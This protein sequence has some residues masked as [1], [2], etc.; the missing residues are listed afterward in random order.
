MPDDSFEAPEGFCSARQAEKAVQELWKVNDAV[1]RHRRKACVAVSLKTVR[2]VEFISDYPEL[3]DPEFVRFATYQLA[4]YFAQQYEEG[5]AD[6]LSQVA[7]RWGALMAMKDGNIPKA[8]FPPATQAI[9]SCSLNTGDRAEG[10]PSSAD[11]FAW[12][13]AALLGMATH[14]DALSDD[15]VELALTWWKTCGKLGGGWSIADLASRFRRYDEEHNS[16]VAAQASVDLLDAMSSGELRG[17]PG[18][19]NN[20]AN[21]LRQLFKHTQDIGLLDRAWLASEDALSADLPDPARDLILANQIMIAISRAAN[22]NAGEWLREYTRKVSSHELSTDVDAAVSVNFNSQAAHLHRWD[23][24]LNGDVIALDRATAAAN[25]AMS[26]VEAAGLGEGP[27]LGTAC[28]AVGAA[29]SDR[30]KVTSDP[31]DGWLAAGAYRSEAAAYVANK[32]QQSHAFSN[33]AG[34][35]LQMYEAQHDFEGLEHAAQSIVAALDQEQATC[36][37]LAL[38]LESAAQIQLELFEAVGDRDHLDK[39]LAHAERALSMTAP[40]DPR[41]ARLEC[42]VAR[43]LRGLGL[44]DNQDAWLQEAMSRFDTAAKLAPDD[45]D[46]GVFRH[47]AGRTALELAMATQDAEAL[48]DARRRL[49][50]LARDSTVPATTRW[51]SAVNAGRL[52]LQLHDRK[53]ALEDQ[54]LGVDVLFTLAWRGRPVSAR[55]AELAPRTS[56]LSEA[57]HLAL[58]LGEGDRALQ[59]A[60]RGRAVVWQELLDLR[61]LEGRGAEPIE[62]GSPSL[63]SV[64]RRVRMLEARCATARAEHFPQSVIEQIEMDLRVADAEWQAI[65]GTYSQQAAQEP[66]TME[67]L[68][69]SLCEGQSLI[70][71][72]PGESSGFA[73]HLPSG[74]TIELPGLTT[75]GCAS[76]LSSYSE[77]FRRFLRIREQEAW[78]ELNKHCRRL[79]EWTWSTVSAPVFAVSDGV[80]DPASLHRIFWYALGPAALLPL[81]SASTFSASG[82]VA[83]SV[84]DRCTSASIVSLVPIEHDTTDRPLSPNQWR[85]LAA[86]DAAGLPTL[87]GARAEYRAVLHA[88]G[89]PDQGLDLHATANDLLEAIAESRAVHV[90]CHANPLSSSSESA[91]AMTDRGVGLSEIAFSEPLSLQWAFMSACST[92]DAPLGVADQG[93]S[94][95]SGLATLG[96]QHVIGTLWQ[97]SDTPATRFATMMYEELITAGGGRPSYTPVAVETATR[98]L[99]AEYE[100]Y[101]VVWAP[102]QY[103]TH[104]RRPKR[105]TIGI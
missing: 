3:S 91:V 65:R 13:E 64:A 32:H 90:A 73:L 68:S 45:W 56:T 92:A 72:C 60:E 82:E 57:V 26:I 49:R 99:R 71:L 48:A 54:S 102:Y 59:V 23:Y 11:V 83:D 95:A 37:E 79:L 55:F 30:Y 75:T 10:G 50:E 12:N 42:A 35:Q 89:I 7:F 31:R 21:A 16:R 84:L 22:G 18:F 39:A 14:A 66:V 29:Y 98:R 41:R 47:F 96:C 33:L 62:E 46:R 36:P 25:R 94:L 40:S 85:V 78:D 80:A 77:S 1:A 9:I 2:R 70:I 28:S 4:Y 76:Q 63:S 5:V 34:V 27:Q 88:I 81:H 15:M 44:L 100:P 104:L 67:S 6:A 58:Q 19:Q 38:T 53:G 97:L 69:D 87:P 61:R 20:H 105:E 52:S 93:A 17:D 86:P 43:V 74:R 101:P 24:Y 8:V 103:L 51:D